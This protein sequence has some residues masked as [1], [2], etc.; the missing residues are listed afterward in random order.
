MKAVVDPNVL[1]VANGQHPDVSP[2][3][4]EECVRRLL[5]MEKSG[6]TVIDDGFRVLGEYLHKTKLNPPKG[7]G[8]L[9]LKSLLRNA[10]NPARVEQ[11]RLTESAENEFDECPDHALQPAFDPLDRKFVA[12]ANAHPD[13]PP[14]WRA[15]DCTWLDWW[16]SLQ[17]KGVKVDF[18]CP[19]D[20][21]GFYRKKFPDNP[22]PALPV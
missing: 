9:F 21:C 13:K 7:V 2:E 17:N 8:D 5:T 6:I 16:P 1:L 10:G 4:I 14:I 22:L 11:V 3:C 15:A 12:A 20:A 19:E 18:L